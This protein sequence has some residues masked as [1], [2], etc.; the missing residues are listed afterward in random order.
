M[1]LNKEKDLSNMTK[2]IWGFKLQSVLK[3]HTYVDGKYLD[4]YLVGLFKKDWI[5][6]R[7]DK[8]KK[9]Q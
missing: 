4:S 7:G 8:S 1:E 2:K 6:L 3:K 9:S 5:K